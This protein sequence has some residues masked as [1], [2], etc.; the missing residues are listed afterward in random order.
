M[1][2][3]DEVTY[4]QDLDIVTAS[5]HV[6]ITQGARVLRADAV[7]Y[8]RRVNLITASG[9]VTLLEPTGDV[10][11]A[12]YVELKDDFR[13][14]IV[15]NFRAVLADQSR[16]AARQRAPRRRPAD[17]GAQGG[18]Q[19]VRAV[20]DRSDPRARLADQGGQDRAR[21]GIA[22]DHLQRRQDGA[23]R[24]SHHVHARIFR[25]PTGR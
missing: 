13:D 4:D 2:K 18:L 24:R 12:D 17:G 11:F 14:G 15:Q 23:V 20:Q 8:N 19:P 9:N 1:F 6:E 10:V 21:P 3:A 25:I 7:S 22:P 5:G 16:I